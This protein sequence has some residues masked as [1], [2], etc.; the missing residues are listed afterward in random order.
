VRTTHPF[1]LPLTALSALALCLAAL[2]STRAD[3][4]FDGP[5]AETGDATAIAP[6]SATLNGVVDTFGRGT[7]VFFQYGPTAAYGAKTPEQVV[8]G[9]RGEVPVSADVTGLTPGTV[10][11]YRIVAYH[12][13]RFREI[14]VGEDRT[15]A[16]PAAPVAPIPA[17]PAP[18]AQPTALAALTLGQSVGLAPVKGTVTVKVPGAATFTALGA[19]ATVPV[20]AVLDTRKGT[21]QLTTA[22]EGGATQT[23]TF[24]S[25]VFE[26]RQPANG[27]G[28][29]DIVLRGPALTCPR[30]RRSG[31]AS[32]RAAA[33]QTKRRPPRRQLWAR[34]KGGRFRTHGKN[35]VATVRGTSWVTTDTCAGTRTTV[36]EGAVS[37]RDTRRHRTVLV[38]AGKSYL[39]RRR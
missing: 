10:Y 15:F 14:D 37:V 12:P 6:T 25:G 31:R 20:G 2:T 18:A 38:R 23:A 34:D 8:A 29:T 26:V 30:V 28:L 1:L 22:V 27:R 13:G 3:A 21:V 36:R 33:A 7:Q 19:G 5:R 9:G 11:H 35:S 16:P 17:T 39:A 24:H 4:H 32:V